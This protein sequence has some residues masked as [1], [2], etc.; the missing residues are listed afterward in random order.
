MTKDGNGMWMMCYCL[1]TLYAILLLDICVVNNM[2]VVCDRVMR[3]T[4]FL[5]LKP[6]IIPTQVSQSDPRSNTGIV[7]VNVLHL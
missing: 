2:L 1:C 5:A 4:S 6:S 3:V 7:V